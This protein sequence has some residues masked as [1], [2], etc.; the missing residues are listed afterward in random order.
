MRPDAQDPQVNEP[1]TEWAQPAV[2]EPV[3]CD[4]GIFLNEDVSF[5]FV[6]PECHPTK[7]GLE[8]KITAR[9]GMSFRLSFAKSARM[10]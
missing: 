10:F 9:K 3:F 8:T 4:D 2:I 6:I 1:Q 7:P 5:A